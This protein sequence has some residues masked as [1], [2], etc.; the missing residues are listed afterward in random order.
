MLHVTT[1]YKQHIHV[2]VSNL[3]VKSPIPKAFYLHI[4]AKDTG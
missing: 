4:K 3:R 1:A 2:A